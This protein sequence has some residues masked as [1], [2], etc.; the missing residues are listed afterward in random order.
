VIDGYREIVNIDISSVAIGMMQK[1]YEHI[2]QLKCILLFFIIEFTFCCIK[3]YQGCFGIVKEIFIWFHY[4]KYFLL[5]AN[6]PSPSA[7]CPHGCP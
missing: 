5:Y 7:R 6:F 4:F 1:K 2:P 3:I